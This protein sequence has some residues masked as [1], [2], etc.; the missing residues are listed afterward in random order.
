MPMVYRIPAQTYFYQKDII[1]VLYMCVLCL[2]SMFLLSREY[3][4]LR[5]R[6]I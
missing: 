5:I 4:H 6:Y 2:L 3:E 1:G